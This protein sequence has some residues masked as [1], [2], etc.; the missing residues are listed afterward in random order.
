MGPFIRDHFIRDFFFA[1]ARGHSR[2]GTPCFLCGVRRFYA[3]FV[4]L[5]GSAMEWS[6]T[7][8]LRQTVKSCSSMRYGVA[9]A[10]ITV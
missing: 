3:V 4:L 6:S 9:R 10:S 1:V 5:Y 7:L 8:A 2:E